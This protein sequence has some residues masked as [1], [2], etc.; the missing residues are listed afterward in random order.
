VSSPNEIAFLYKPFPPR[1]INRIASTK[2]HTANYEHYFNRASYDTINTL[3]RM[4]CSFR[5]K[6]V[7]VI[8]HI[9]KKNE[10]VLLN[11]GFIKEAHI[12]I[13]F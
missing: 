11:K 8:E 12:K 9:Q 1:T 2:E 7:L 5:H 4:L 3:E 10:G 13:G 6:E